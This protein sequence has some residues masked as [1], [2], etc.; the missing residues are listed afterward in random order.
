MHPTDR[1]TFD[2]VAARLDAALVVV[3]AR[4]GERRDGCLVGFHSQVGIEPRRYGVWLS[5]A[6]RTH[7]VARDA[8]ALAVHVLGA[9]DHPLA[10]WFGG[11]TGDDGDPFAGVAIDDG[12]LGTVLVRALRTRVVGRVERRVA[13]GTDHEL[14]VL[15][16]VT[17]ELHDDGPTLRLGDAGDIDAGHPAD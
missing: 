4:A 1:A 9:A 3:T 14:F 12:P 13:V 17:A 2:A 15:E 16:P 8:D 6:N 5:T 10:A 7:R 11:V